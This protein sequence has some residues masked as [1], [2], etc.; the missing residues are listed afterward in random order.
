MKNSVGRQDVIGACR[1]DG[2]DSKKCESKPRSIIKRT[3]G[4]ADDYGS[5]LD[6]EGDLTLDITGQAACGLVRVDGL[7]RPIRY[8][9]R[10]RR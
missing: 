3:D 8:M 2:R 10:Q 4:E 7:V 1:N 9:A 5:K 6:R